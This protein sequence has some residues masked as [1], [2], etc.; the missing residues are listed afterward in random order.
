M[1]TWSHVAI[2]VTDLDRS[3]AFYEELCGLTVVRDRRKEGGGTVWL[4]YPPSEGDPTF[5]LV[6]D[7]DPTASSRIDHLGF[8]CST[9]ELVDAKAR[10][11]EERGILVSA[12]KDSGGSIA[13]WTML[14]DPDG[15]RVEFACGQPLRGFR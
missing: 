9:R 1:I 10:V 4:G 5:V 8:E 13:Y 14:R 15:H 2:S 3:I 12:P 11:A 7:R 6:L